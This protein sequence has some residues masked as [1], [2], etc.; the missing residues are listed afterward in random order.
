MASISRG[1]TITDPMA[2]E[3]REHP[4]FLTDFR[5]D[6]VILNGEKAGEEVSGRAMNLSKGGLRLDLPIAVN[7]GT[8]LS[9]VIY[10]E[11]YDSLCVGGVVWVQRTEPGSRC[12]VKISRWTYVDAVLERQ[13]PAR[14]PKI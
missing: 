3:R 14:R 11:G 2:P 4:R 6:T 12:G 10:S 13:F 9:L 7:V 1:A 8:Q 5:V